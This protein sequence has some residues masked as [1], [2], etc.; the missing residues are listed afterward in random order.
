M[1]ICEAFSVIIRFTL[2]YTVGCC[3]K[4]YYKSAVIIKY[5]VG[6]IKTVRK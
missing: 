3:A 6:L 5:C 4:L 1:E 2:V